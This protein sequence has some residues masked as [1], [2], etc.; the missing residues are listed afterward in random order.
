MTRLPSLEVNERIALEALL[1]VLTSDIA[2]C[3]KL[4]RTP[5]PLGYTRYSVRFLWIWLTLLPFALTNTF[6]NFGVGTWWEDKP[7]PVLVLAMLFIG[8]IF[9]SIEDIAV[10][11]EEPFAILPLEQHQRWL[12]RDARQVKALFA[13]LTGSG[14]RAP[15]QPPAGGGVAEGRVAGEGA[16][17]VEGAARGSPSQSRQAN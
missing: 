15:A 7:K 17:A 13:H 3:E 8:F 10:Q 4:L 6:V 5:I 2:S 12:L 11:I 9:L 14:V 1:S 16:E